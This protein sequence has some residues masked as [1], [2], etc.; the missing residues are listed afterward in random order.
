MNESEKTVCVKA[1]DQGKT[2]EEKNKE[3]K[4]EGIETLLQDMQVLQK[5]I[6][7]LK[8]FGLFL[9]VW[10]LGRFGF[11]CMWVVIAA[12]CYYIK[13]TKQEKREW[14]QKVGE[15]LAKDE[16]VTIR[17]R[18]KDLPSWVSILDSLYA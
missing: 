15:A 18:L 5:I 10:L 2:N 14:K 3:A 7:F 4:P 1:E 8:Y 12:I 6:T 16:E 11:G 9:F 13:R 17:A